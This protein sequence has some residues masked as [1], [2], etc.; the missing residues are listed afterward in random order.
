MPVII[1]CEPAIPAYVD[2]VESPWDKA[3]KLTDD[4]TIQV[5]CLD[6]GVAVYCDEDGVAKNLAINRYLP[7]TMPEI[8]D[9]MVVIDGT[10][11]NHPEPGEIGVHEI[12]G[13][14]ILTREIGEDGWEDLSEND[15]ARYLEL[16]NQ[17]LRVP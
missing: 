5:V 2:D 9:G 17:Q 11:G 16:L 14:F 13:P 10:N 3:K 7:A 6:D 1:V 4:A 15:V 12:R 8:P